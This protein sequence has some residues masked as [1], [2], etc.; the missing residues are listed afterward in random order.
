MAQMANIVMVGDLVASAEDL[1]AE[2]LERMEQ[3][4]LAAALWECVEDLPERSGG[5]APE[6]VPAGTTAERYCCSNGN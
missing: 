6:A 4:R 3:E 1:E 5:G 2:V